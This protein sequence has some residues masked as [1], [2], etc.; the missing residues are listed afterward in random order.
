MAKDKTVKLTLEKDTSKTLNK[1]KVRYKDENNH[2]IYLQGDE[3][4]KLGDPDEVEVT[5]KQAGE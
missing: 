5:I 3:V 1:G 2:N 4:K